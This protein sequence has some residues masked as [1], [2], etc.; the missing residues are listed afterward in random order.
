MLQLDDERLDLGAQV[1]CSLPG[2]DFFIRSVRAAWDRCAGFL[3]LSKLVL[4][5]GEGVWQRVDEALDPRRG[6]YR[7]RPRLRRWRR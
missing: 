2:E 5:L 4:D 1:L 6:G 3:G 7:A